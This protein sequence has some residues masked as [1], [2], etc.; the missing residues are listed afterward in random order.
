LARGPTYRVLF[1]RRREGKT[2]YYVRMKLLRSGKPRLVVRKTLNS[3]VVQVTNAKPEGDHVIAS[4]FSKEL[5]KQGWLGGSGNTPSA[6]LTGYLA[7]LRASKKGVKEAV[8]DLGL[9][10]PS[11]GSR[12]F[13]ALKGFVD[14]GVNV[15][16]D[17]SILP[18]EERIRGE[19]IASYA[20]GLSQSNPEYYQKRFSDYLKKGL[21]P[22]RL[23]KHFSEV[24][25]KANQSVGGK[26]GER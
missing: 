11:S 3:M 15:S 4:A 6:Y 26:R 7:G 1:R 12:I 23:P 18:S 16:H 10:S 24:K 17:K 5:R 9:G 22:Q 14:A 19:H 20:K 13:A 21:D 25:E 8:L 2:D